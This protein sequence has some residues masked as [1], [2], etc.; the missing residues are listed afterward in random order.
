MVRRWQ[1]VVLLFMVVGCQPPTG[2]PSAAPSPSASKALTFVKPQR[3][4]LVRVVDQPGAVE[5]FEQTQLVAR[6][7]GYVRKV[8]ADIG[9]RVVGP[10]YDANGKLTEPGRLLAELDVPELIEES[11]QKDAMKKL[12]EAEVLLAQRS[13]AAADAHIATAESLVNE[14][15]AGLA[16]V[17][18]QYERWE[19]ESRRLTDLTSRGVIDAQ[20]RDETQK[21]FQAATASR[22]EAQSRLASA[23]AAVRKAQADRAKGEAEIAVAQ[24]KVAVAAAEAQRLKALLEFASI[25]AP[26]DGVVTQRHVNPG[27]FLQPSGGKASL[28]TITRL[29]PVRVVLHVP[30]MDAGLIDEKTEVKL[31]IA[32]HGNS[33]LAAKITRTSWALE[34]GAR[35]LRAEIDLP[36]PEGKLRPG[37]F[38]FAKLEAKLPE[39]WTLP[40][41]CISKQGDQ[42]TGRLSLGGAEKRVIVRPGFSDGQL[43]Q[44]LEYRI[45]GNSEWRVVTAEEQFGR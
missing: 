36:N 45:D 33:V 32:A 13:L 41:A 22:D 23:A 27:D 28:F 43:T 16:R 12:A 31:A 7:P 19:S 34:S 6:L 14:A 40:A 15:R 8:N 38:V 25:R 42:W 1:A 29:D 20:T 21:Q 4:S 11:R 39:A 2:L 44:V 9:Q 18:A 5:P 24:A 30:E 17:Q 37:M 10:R 26:F 3:R 35:T